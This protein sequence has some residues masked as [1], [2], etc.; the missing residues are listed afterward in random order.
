[1][2][3][4]NPNFIIDPLKVKPLNHHFVIAVGEGTVTA[5]GIVVTEA[6]TTTHIHGTIIRADK[7]ITRLEWV[8]E[9]IKDLKPGDRVLFA[10]NIRYEIPTADG[11][12]CKHYLVPLQ[13]IIGVF[14]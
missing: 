11:G 5:S 1:M 9:G 14:E 10:P 7:D 2:Y 8:Q 13:A 3:N 12:A 6:F 4:D